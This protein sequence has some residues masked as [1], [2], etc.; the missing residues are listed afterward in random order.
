MKSAASDSKLNS[1]IPLRNAGLNGQ[2][3]SFDGGSIKT[4]SIA[5]LSKSTSRYKDQ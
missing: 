1:V 4:P 5:H 2:Q 3:K